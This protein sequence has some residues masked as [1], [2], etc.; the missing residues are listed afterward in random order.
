MAR[1]SLLGVVIVVT[2]LL[3]SAGLAASAPPSFSNSGHRSS[4]AVVG[5]GPAIVS[6][7]VTAEGGGPL[8]ADA[9]VGGSGGTVQTGAD[10][11]SVGRGETR[12][13]PGGRPFPG[14]APTTPARTLPTFQN[15]V[16]GTGP[17]LGQFHGD[18]PAYGCALVCSD[19]YRW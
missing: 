4:V 14:S 16:C 13:P 5:N 6:P 10:T 19:A 3:A 15:M 2:L 18:K 12:S 9:H 8:S 7:S 17:V 1:R 11:H